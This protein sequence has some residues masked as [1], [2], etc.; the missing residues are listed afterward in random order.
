M[1]AAPILGFDVQAAKLAKQRA[2]LLPTDGRAA[3]EVQA[4]A[5]S[6]ALDNPQPDSSSPSEPP[7]PVIRSRSHI[8]MAQVQTLHY[9]GLLSCMSGCWYNGRPLEV[10]LL[11][12]IYCIDHDNKAC[13]IEVV[14]AWQP[15]SSIFSDLSETNV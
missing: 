3:M 6:T 13:S 1:G 14:G 11:M 10:A 2:S 8:P 9:I 12:A 5:S 15:A 7:Q 4:A